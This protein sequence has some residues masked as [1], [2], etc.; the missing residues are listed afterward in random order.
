MRK[1]MTIAVMLNLLTGC[2]VLYCHTK[3]SEVGCALKKAIRDEYK[4][5]IAL[6]EF[7]KFDWDEFFAFDP[8]TPTEDVCRKLKIDST[9]CKK[10]IKMESTGDGEMLLVF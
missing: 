7:T 8:Y 4:Q 5:E 1:L 3:G 2:G 10:T 6:K 9:D